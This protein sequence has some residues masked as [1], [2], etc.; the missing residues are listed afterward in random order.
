MPD[1]QAVE[2]FSGCVLNLDLIQKQPHGALY[3]FYK[4]L[5][6]LRRT[7]PAVSGVCKGSIEVRDL[8][9]RL[10]SVQNQTD[11][12]DI[13][14]LFCF[15]DSVEAVFTQ[16]ARGT[17]RK[18]IDSEDTQWGGAGSSVPEQIVGETMSSIKLSGRSFVVLQKESSG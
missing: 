9:G 3:E 16:L 4:R 12:H 1:P 15:G 6:L 8:P 5:I 18:V 7:T 13:L 11:A 17:W 14:I 2:T 10:L